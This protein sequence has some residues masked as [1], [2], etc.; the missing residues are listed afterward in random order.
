MAEEGESWD[1]TYEVNMPQESESRKTAQSYEIKR[2]CRRGLKV[3]CEHRTLGMQ[4]GEEK[5]GERKSEVKSEGGGEES[6]HVDDLEVVLR[7]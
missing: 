3:V 2:K 1:S 5:D 6:E 4:F 7:N